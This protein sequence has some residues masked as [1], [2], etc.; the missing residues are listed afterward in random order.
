M[1]LLS[2]SNLSAVCWICTDFGVLCYLTYL[3]PLYHAMQ[4]KLLGT[5]TF[6]I[7]DASWTIGSLEQ[8]AVGLGIGCILSWVGLLRYLKFNYKFH[9]SCYLIT[10][11]Y[12]LDKSQMNVE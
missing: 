9:V 6:Y 4:V 1:P 2:V 5:Y 10:S 7:Q 12:L 11:Q 3:L 8:Y